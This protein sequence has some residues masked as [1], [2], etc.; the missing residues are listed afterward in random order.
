MFCLELSTLNTIHHILH[1]E[2]NWRTNRFHFL[3]ACFT[4]CSKDVSDQKIVLYNYG[5][6]NS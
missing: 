3:L 4:R 1:K 2:Q 6:R 5:K